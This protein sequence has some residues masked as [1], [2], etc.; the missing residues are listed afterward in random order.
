MSGS[1][2]E[3]NR[4]TFCYI[5]SLSS[6]CPLPFPFSLTIK[7]PTQ[8]SLLSPLTISHKDKSLLK[9]MRFLIPLALFVAAVTAADE[10]PEQLLKSAVPECLQSCIKDAMESATN[11][12]LND[13]DC[14]CKAD[15][16]T[17][18]DSTLNSVVDD[19]QTCIKNSATKCSEDDLNSLSE[20]AIN[21]AFSN[22]EGLCPNSGAA[23]SFSPTN[24]LLGA[25]AMMI[26]AAI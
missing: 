22:V 21:S 20:D 4:S 8:V 7:L 24:A 12:S 9:K 16:K 11:C 5:T 26:V 18:S 3:M 23:V 10:T 13:V 15:A 14:L 1:S 25:G 19:L 17:Y 6:L 2:L